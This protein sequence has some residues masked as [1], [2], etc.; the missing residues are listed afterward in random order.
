MTAITAAVSASLSAA[1]IFAP[2]QATAGGASPIAGPAPTGAVATPDGTQRLHVRE[3]RHGTLIRAA[4]RTRGRLRL[5]APYTLQAVAY[6]GTPGG[7]SADGRTLVLAGPPALS[8]QGRTRFAIVDAAK[9][10]VRR[11]LTLKGQYGFDALSPDGRWLYL[12]EATERTPG[13]YSVRAYDLRRGRMRPGVIIDPSEK[14]VEMWGLPMARATSPDGRFEYTLY[15]GRDHEFIHVLDTVNRK[16][17]CIDLPHL[18]AHVGSLG[19][20]MA[21]DGKRLSLD[22][23]GEAVANVDLASYAVSLPSHSRR[24]PATTR[25][26]APVETDGGGFPWLLLPAAGLLLAGGLIPLRRWR[27]ASPTRTATP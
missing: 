17:K 24:E 25:E 5:D 23:N 21:S 11:T 2:A 13:A 15:D 10:R 6:D 12:I 7:L 16:A 4:G 14:P 18:P 22:R 1:V 3:L 8:Q 27:A 9:L 26:A 20:A 19:M